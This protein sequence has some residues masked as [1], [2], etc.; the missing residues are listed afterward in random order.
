MIRIAVQGDLPVLQ[1]ICSAAALSNA[2][3]AALLQAH[4][5]FLVLAGDG[6]PE[7]RTRVA[8]IAG[9]NAGA[10]VG[11]ATVAL[12]PS[13]GLE[14][15]DLFVAPAWHRRGIARAL[16]LDAGDVARRGG[17]GRLSVDA[18]LHAMPFYLA[19]GF[20][21]VGQLDVDHGPGVRLELDLLG[22]PR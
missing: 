13:G 8:T 16:V 7:G 17:H 2:G 9:E 18:N 1:Q 21:E 11:F 22:A 3:D 5:E 4:P 19:V 14:L 6:I 12:D 20:V 15:E 10:P